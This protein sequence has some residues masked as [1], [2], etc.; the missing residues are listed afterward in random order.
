MIGARIPF[1]NVA[2]A[3]RERQFDGPVVR[4]LNRAPG[5]VVEIRRRGGGDVDALLGEGALVQAEAEVA[6]D[7]AGV[8]EREA[9]AEIHQQAFAPAGV[10]RRAAQRRRRRRRR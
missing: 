2:G 8:A 6:G 9:P 10:E 3:G 4:Q 1:R 7:V 5:A